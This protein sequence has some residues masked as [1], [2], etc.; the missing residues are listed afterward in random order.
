M[1]IGAHQP[2]IK[3]QIALISGLITGMSLQSIFEAWCDIAGSMES[4]ILDVDRSGF[5]ARAPGCCRGRSAGHETPAVPSLEGLRSR[6]SHDRRRAPIARPRR[7]AGAATRTTVPFR[8]D[9]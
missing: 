8:R 2:D 1:R 6:R 3:M 4:S 9:G 7:A 5:G